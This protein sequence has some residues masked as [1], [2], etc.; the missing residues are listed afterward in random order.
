VSGLTLSVP[1]LALVLIGCQGSSTGPRAVLTPATLPTAGPAPATEPAEPGFIGVV[2]AGEWAEIEAKVEGRIEEVFVR[3][4]DVVT[5]GAPIARLDIEASEHELAIARAGFAEA[6]RRLGRRRKLARGRL[7]AVT[8]EEMD[9][10][11]RE[12]LEARARLAKLTQV[13]NQALVTAPFDG[14]VA[15]RY[16]APGALAGPGR[17]IVRLLG[18]G[19]PRVRFAIPEER[20]GTISVGAMVNITVGPAGL[21]ARG[22][23][24]GLSPEIDVS[25]RMVFAAATLEPAPAPPGASAEPLSTGLLARVFVVKGGR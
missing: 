15:E 4:G 1:A 3:A 17:A 12:M 23:V 16:L 25:A 20:A 8:V 19:A 6:S 2:V 7:P 11:R 21:A 10:A 18:R 24:T 14:T 13:T 22:R 9:Q 5:K